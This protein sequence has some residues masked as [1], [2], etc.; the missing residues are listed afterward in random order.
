M[1]NVTWISRDGHAAGTGAMHGWV[2]IHRRLRGCPELRDPVARALWVDLLLLANHA[3]GTVPFRGKNVTLE[4][5]QLVTSLRQLEADTNIPMQKLR[6]L[7][8]KFTAA[9][10]LKTNTETN[11]AGNAVGSVVTICNYDA[12]QTEA[13]E[14]TQEIPQNQHGSN[15]H[16]KKNKNLDSSANA[17]GGDPPPSARKVLWDE[18]VRCVL[19]DWENQGR[20]GTPKKA[21]DLI[22]KWLS[23][24][25]DGFVFGAHFAATRPDPLQGVA[26]D[27]AGYVGYVGGYLRKKPKKPGKAASDTQRPA[28]PPTNGGKPLSPDQ[29]RQIDARLREEGLSRFDIEGM[30]RFNQLTEEMTRDQRH[31]AAA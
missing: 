26:C 3:S 25:D 24:Y 31:A 2:K 28:P 9:G 10:M 27:R 13:E 5:G 8:A 11:T 16:T 6:T 4:R 30:A 17:E 21:R 23:Q 12:F 15:T 18:M 1:S 14:P 7:L 19:A 20:L 22:G 29:K